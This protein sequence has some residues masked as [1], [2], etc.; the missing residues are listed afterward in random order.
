MLKFW[1]RGR[2]VLSKIPQSST[3]VVSAAAAT[4]HESFTQR[5]S[6]LDTAGHRRRLRQQHTDNRLL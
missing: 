1:K 3:L 5:A 4:S 6:R 2:V